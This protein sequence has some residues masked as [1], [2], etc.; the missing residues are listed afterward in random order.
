MA[1]L[2]K[3]LNDRR[4]EGIASAKVKLNCDQPRMWRQ[5][6]Y[7]SAKWNIASQTEDLDQKMFSSLEKKLG[8]YDL[9]K[10]EH[11]FPMETMFQEASSTIQR[12]KFR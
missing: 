3:D 11:P 6:A 8:I 4:K 10:G 2:S 7:L 12:E 9:G 5:W 1:C